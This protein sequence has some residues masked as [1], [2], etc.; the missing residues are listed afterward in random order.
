M[1]PGKRTKSTLLRFFQIP[2]ILLNRGS[3]SYSLDDLPSGEVIYD[4]APV[5]QILSAI[6][7][8]QIFKNLNTSNVM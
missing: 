2:N 3:V 4:T 5:M 8:V 1:H 7:Y 6:Y